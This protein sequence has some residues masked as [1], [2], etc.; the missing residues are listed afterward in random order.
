MAA[1]ASPAGR[2]RVVLGV[3]DRRVCAEREQE[4]DGRPVAAQGCLVQRGDAVAGVDVEA[5]L[6]E[7]RHDGRPV[8]LDGAGDEVGMFPEDG[9]EELRVG[10]QH[11]IDRGSVAAEAGSDEA[12]DRRHPICGGTGGRKQIGDDQVAVPDRALI[13]TPS[14]EARMT[15]PLVRVDTAGEQ[16]PDA[17][18]EVV[19][20]G[21]LQR[22][23][24]DLDR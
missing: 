20:G 16:Q 14:G 9:R 12:I 5:D 17:P 21:L 15:A 4:V 22:L 19:L 1:V 7:Q 6:D 3:D 13:R 24:G 8:E 10:G 2:G 18:L 11:P 23:R